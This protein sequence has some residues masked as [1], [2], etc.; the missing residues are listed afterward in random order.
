[1]RALSLV[2]ML[3][4]LPAG[5]AGA[6]EGHVV[7]P[8]CEGS[9]QAKIDAASPGS[10][11][12]L[13]DGCVYRESV[14]VDKPLAIRGAGE[15]EIRGSDVW[16]DWA[17]EESLWRS[18]HRVPDLS[19]PPNYRCEGASRRCRWP[20]QVFVD[21]R[22]LAQVVSD[23]RAGQF[24]LDG[25]RRVVLADDPAG[26]VVEVTV[27]ERWVLG[28]AADV[29]VLGTTMKHAAGD[30][31]WNGGYPSWSVE[32][33]DL[34]W[35]HAKNLSLTLGGSLVAEDNDLHDAGQMGMNSNDAEIRITGNRIYDNGVE[36][37]DPGW[38]AGGMKIAQPRTAQILD[39]EVHHN[40]DIGIW[41]DVVNGEQASV[42]IAH[43][44]VHHQPA[45]GI[46]VEVTKNFDVYDNV[47]WE[48]GWGKGD[49]YN[50][51]GIT[52]AGSHDGTVD[53]NVLAWNASGVVVVQQD[54]EGAGEHPYNYVK[55]VRL[56]R[57]RIVQDEPPGS[58]N[59]AAV[60]WN[61]GYGATARGFPSP[62]DAAAN[63][64]GA[65][66]R[67]WFDGPEGATSRF[68][69]E[70]RL[71]DLDAFNATPAEKNGRYLTDAGKDSLLEANNL[72]TAPEDRPSNP[73]TLLDRILGL[74]CRLSLC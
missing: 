69:W 20:E 22:P 74:L 21:G 63:N 42:E 59:H 54:R 68:K 6:E 25:D 53:D 66:S 10:E 41:I 71:E 12:V 49:S 47:L 14:T 11:V 70:A 61:E 60:V 23:P 55:N 16:G 17:K 26:R 7:G 64:G 5:S 39:N 48:N 62:Y 57:N 30:G 31:L 43:N 18:V 35:A 58:L 72:P 27:R 9:L 19:V 33:N 28:A 56:N 37:F 34:S 40:R 3:A 13:E 65:E 32:G 8:T 50:G 44:R 46:R 15:G 38:A 73:V 1:L 67:Y 24:A 2:V 29:S 52:V 45:Q 4:L 36:G 51:A